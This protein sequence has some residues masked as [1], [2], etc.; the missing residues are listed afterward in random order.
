MEF[1]IF[2]KYIRVNI[3]NRQVRR[4]R[5]LKDAK[6]AEEH[7]QS[8][9]SSSSLVSQDRGSSFYGGSGVSNDHGSKTTWIQWM[10]DWIEMIKVQSRT[11]PFNGPVAGSSFPYPF[12][13]SCQA[14]LGRHGT[15]KDDV[16][17]LSA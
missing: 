8:P 12:A 16:I 14:G 6:D 10:L 5:S 11:V 3:T 15:A 9:P 2:T 7:Q 4:M 1:L 17:S 13:L